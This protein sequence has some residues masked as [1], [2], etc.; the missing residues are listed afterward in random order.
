MDFL[1]R[2]RELH[3]ISQIAELEFCKIPTSF[4]LTTVSNSTTKMLQLYGGAATVDIQS[5]SHYQIVDVSHFRQIPD[6]QE[7][8]IL[9]SVSPSSGS[10]ESETSPWSLNG[11]ISIIFDILELVPGAYESAIVTHIEDLV[12]SGKPQNCVVHNPLPGATHAQTTSFIVHVNDR[13]DAKQ[14]SALFILTFISLVRLQ[15]VESDILVTMNVPLDREYSNADVSECLRGDGNAIATAYSV[16]K[17]LCLSFK[18]VNWDL[19][20]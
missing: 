13:R 17:T 14:S 1:S 9:E 8:F 11:D 20:G 16:F 15:N 3:Q 6:T 2:H 18:I 19:F 10:G 4:I 12:E 5:S 7:V